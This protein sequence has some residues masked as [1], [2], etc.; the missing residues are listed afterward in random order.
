[1]FFPHTFKTEFF[2]PDIFFFFSFL[3]FTTRG[4]NILINVFSVSQ[5]KKKN[6]EIKKVY[7][8]Q[9]DIQKKNRFSYFIPWKM[10]S[11]FLHLKKCLLLL[12]CLFYTLN[13]FFSHLI[14]TLERCFFTKSHTWKINSEKNVLAQFQTW[15]K[16]FLNF[17]LFYSVSRQKCF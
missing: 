4:K 11:P 14:K 2:F 12:F 17:K 7:F 6:P 10:F 9:F 1:M 8:A 5:L 16:F 15:K 13:T 3:S